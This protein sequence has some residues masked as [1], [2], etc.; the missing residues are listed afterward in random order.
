MCKII[1]R[2]TGKSDNLCHIDGA[3]SNVWLVQN[4]PYLATYIIKGADWPHPKTKEIIMTIFQIIQKA[5]EL[6]SAVRHIRI[7]TDDVDKCPEYK[8]AVKAYN[9][10]MSVH[11]KTVDENYEAYVKLTTKY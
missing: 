9:D 10:F 2:L 1:S 8:A 6:G 11:Q 7:A 4:G 3:R 5:E